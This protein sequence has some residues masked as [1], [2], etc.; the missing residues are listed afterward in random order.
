MT[1]TQV[2]SEIGKMH[3]D[4][5]MYDVLINNIERATNP[6]GQH[7]TNMPSPNL[8]PTLCLL[9]YLSL[10]LTSPQVKSQQCTIRTSNGLCPFKILRAVAF[11]SSLLSRMS[12]IAS[13][14]FLLLIRRP[15]KSLQDDTQEEELFIDPSRACS[16]MYIHDGAVNHTEKIR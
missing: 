3:K 8:L 14:R 4:A 2:K 12:L 5:N 16:N 11:L 7:L 13:R 10:L 1:T 15:F 6:Q 9:S